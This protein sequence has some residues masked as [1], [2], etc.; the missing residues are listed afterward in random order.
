MGR[1]LDCGAHLKKLRRTACDHLRVEQAIGLEEL[2]TMCAR[3][4]APLLS[5]REALVHLPSVTWQSRLLSRLRLGQ[6]DL[7]A[8]IAKPRDCA[9]L[10][11]ILDPRGE[12]AA[13]AKWS[14]ESSGG[15]WRLHRVFHA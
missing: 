3:D 12:L 2:E 7:L 15:R 4:G 5:L 1:E 8:Q 13:L 6:Q 9:D 11:G 10:V 14:D